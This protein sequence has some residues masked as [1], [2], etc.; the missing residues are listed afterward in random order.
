MKADKGTIKIG[1][2]E[3]TCKDI[4]ITIKNIMEEHRKEFYAI[5]EIAKMQKM[6]ENPDIF[7][8]ELKLNELST[9]SN[10]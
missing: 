10:H 7:Q 4:E 3:I 9:A 1:N 5:R 6:Y 2:T 8:W